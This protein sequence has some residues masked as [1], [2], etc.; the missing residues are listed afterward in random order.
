MTDRPG[1]RRHTV[2]A[3]RR[4]LALIESRAIRLL[5][6]AHDTLPTTAPAPPDQL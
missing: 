1:S 5:I 4:H 2:M 3:W 6:A